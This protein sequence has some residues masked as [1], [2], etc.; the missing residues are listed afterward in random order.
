[1]CIS[2][3]VLVTRLLLQLGRETR[4]GRRRTFF[5]PATS[6]CC[7]RASRAPGEN[8]P[9][10][11]LKTFSLHQSTYHSDRRGFIAPLLAQAGS[12]NYICNVIHGMM[13]NIRA[14][15]RTAA[16]Q[17]RIKAASLSFNSGCLRV[18]G[19]NLHK[20]HLVHIVKPVCP[21]KPI[22]FPNPTYSFR[23]DKCSILH[24][25]FFRI[26]SWRGSIPLFL[27]L[28]VLVYAIRAARVRRSLC[29]AARLSVF[30]CTWG[31]VVGYWVGG[32]WHA[33]GSWRTL[34]SW[35]ALGS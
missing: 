4:D 19:R 23:E 12:Q 28:G 3:S 16:Y 35:H 26:P 24:S 2:I 7:R 11:P 1:M 33:L 8:V 21:N 6:G 14:Y 20:V 27:F 18:R 30:G 15:M 34:G 10:I 13:A 5:D 32:S 29:R 31:C 9:A 25:L 17:K 22:A